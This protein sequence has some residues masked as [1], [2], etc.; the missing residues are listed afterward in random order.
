MPD[1]TGRRNNWYK[2]AMRMITRA[3]FEVKCRRLEKEGKIRR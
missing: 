3:E 2:L 1:L